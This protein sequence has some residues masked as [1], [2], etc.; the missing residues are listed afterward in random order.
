MWHRIMAHPM[1]TA[2]IIVAAGSGQ[3]A[4]G[5]LPKQLVPLGGKPMLSWSLDVFL[6]HAQISET[7]LV[8]PALEIERYGKAFPSATTLVAGGDTRA[9]SVKAGLRAIRDSGA[10]DL[11]T[12]VLIHDAAR[13]GLT[14]GIID[15]LLEALS[16][17]DGVAPA[18]PVVDALKRASRDTLQNIDRSDLWRVQTPQGFALDLIEQAL[19]ASDD[20]VVDDLAAVKQIGGRLSLV[21]GSESLS[22]VTYPEDFK[23][24]EAMIA[25]NTTV[26]MGTGF[27]VHAFEPGDGVILCGVIIPHDAKLQGHSDA[28]VAWHALTDSILGALASG[29]IGDHFPPSDPKWAGAA[30]EVF[31]RKAVALTA[32]RGFGISNCDLTIICEAPKVKPHRE[33]MRAKTADILGISIDQ[34]SIKAT[35]TEGLGFTGRREGIAAQAAVVLSKLLR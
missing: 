28:D 16:R 30:S 24:I 15:R 10:G 33:A 31:L 14:D 8:V 21:D 25:G 4:G 32:E 3:R 17:A 6:G 27:D 29:D 7:V 5:E 19:D 1:K 34:V 11:A 35:T 18:L 23:R 12:H 20:S 22:K 26:R 13:P 9:A 2:A